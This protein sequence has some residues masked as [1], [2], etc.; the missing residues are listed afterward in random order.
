MKKSWLILSLPALF[1]SASVLA[2][3]IPLP[4]GEGNLYDAKNGGP[5]SVNIKLNNLNVDYIYD[6]FCFVKDPGAATDHSYIRFVANGVW[7]PSGPTFD[8]ELLQTDQAMLKDN[9][10]HVLEYHSIKLYGKQ[11]D[12]SVTLTRLGGDGIANPINY[13]CYAQF[14]TGLNK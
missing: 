4:N 3:N 12:A 2:S 13:R 9:G 10:D 5:E 1:L 8:Y 14:S 11:T 7:T 6:I